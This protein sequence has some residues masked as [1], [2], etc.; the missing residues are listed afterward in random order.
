MGKRKAIQVGV[1][2]IPRGEVGI[3]VAQ[4]GVAMAAVSGAIYGVVLAMAVVTTLV[5]PP[6][7][8]LAFAG[9]QAEP[10]TAE[11]VSEFESGIG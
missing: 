9:E 2:M 10:F 3:V 7:I 11:Y 1:G 8:K 4:L 6:L 5:A